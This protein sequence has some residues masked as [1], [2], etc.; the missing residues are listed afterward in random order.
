M[1]RPVVTVPDCLLA[2]VEIAWEIDWRSASGGEFL[3]GVTRT[4]FQGFPRW[5]GR[6]RVALDA[7]RLRA[8]RAIRATARGRWGIY[9]LPMA[10]PLTFV[11]T[12]TSARADVLDGMPHADGRRFSS[13][14][15]YL[16]QP[17]CVAHWGASQGAT[18][19]QLDTAPCGGVLPVVG[20]IMSAGDL[21]FMVTWVG[22]AVG[23]VVEVGVEMP[24]RAAVGLG[25]VVLMRGH[26][27]F[28]AADDG[29]GAPVYGAARHARLA[30]SFVEVTW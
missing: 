19:L 23:T 17:Y 2:Q 14:A 12:A 18:T 10:D 11:R 29:M 27:L 8:W 26:G 15:G 3:D 13:G 1:T 7:P 16:V 21:P 20:Q 6:P 28:E 9:R 22:P 5:L 30:L 4:H 24:L 25:D